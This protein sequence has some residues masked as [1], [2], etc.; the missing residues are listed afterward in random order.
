MFALKNEAI[1]LYDLY[2]EEVLQ[3]KRKGFTD[4]EF[5]EMFVGLS[6]KQELSPGTVRNWISKHNNKPYLQPQ[7][8]VIRE[9]EHG[10]R[11]NPDVIKCIATTLIDFPCWSSQTRADYLIEH[12]VVNP[13]KGKYSY[14]SSSVR[15]IIKNLKFTYRNPGAKL[16]PPQR[17]TLGY[18]AARAV[19]ARILLDI[20][21]NDNSLITFADECSVCYQELHKGYYKFVG[22][23]P[24]VVSDTRK[25]VFNTLLLVVP[26]FGI[27]YKITKEP[28]THQIYITFL[29]Q[30]FN[31]VR[32]LVC[33]NSTKIYLV[34]DNAP[35]HTQNDVSPNISKLGVKEVPIIPYS[36]QL[37]EPVECCF[38]FTKQGV[39]AFYHSKKCNKGMISSIGIKNWKNQLRKYDAKES[40]KYFNVWVEILKECI[41]GVPLSDISHIRV[42]DYT[43]RLRNVNT[44][45]LN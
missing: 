5:A 37:N 31:V 15:K 19:W 20:V 16:S 2:N 24:E 17:N 30:A 39:E 21:E 25:F 36:P 27:V 34:H 14:S 3:K 41:N 45:R 9:P 10:L 43:F 8:T 7:L 22:V 1:R 28:T 23:N 44:I 38:G 6:G 29:K 35:Y 11:V 13:V 12:K 26:G 33:T 18:I 42:D 32:S 4:I 40:A